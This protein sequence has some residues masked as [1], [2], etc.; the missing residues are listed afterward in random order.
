ME[1][2]IAEYVENVLNKK[3]VYSTHNYPL[4][5]KQ[6]TEVIEE[7]LNYLESFVQTDFIR[8]KEGLI[9]AFYYNVAYG[10]FAGAKRPEYYACPRDK[11]KVFSK[12]IEGVKDLKAYSC[13]VYI[14]PNELGNA[15]RKYGLSIYTSAKEYGNTQIVF[16]PKKFNA[17]QEL[18]DCDDIPIALFK[19]DDGEMCEAYIEIL[20]ED[21][22]DVDFSAYPVVRE[23]DG[24]KQKC[25]ELNIAYTSLYASS[26]KFNRTA[27]VSRHFITKIN[28]PIMRDVLNLTT[29]YDKIQL[30]YTDGTP[31]DFKKGSFTISASKK[32]EGYITED[33]RRYFA[34]KGYPSSKEATIKTMRDYEENKN[35]NQASM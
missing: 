18:R 23:F 28:R 26:E 30:L 20:K 22:K 4:K 7:N 9:P 13:A 31:L 29:D 19:D 33:F 25:Y 27:D 1:N 11:V 14:D 35:Q 34:A 21:Y 5:L 2:K 3:I 15:T 17:Y 8:P 10:V 6:K 32:V 16:N 24:Q 12:E